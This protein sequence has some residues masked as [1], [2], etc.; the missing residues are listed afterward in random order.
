M[1]TQIQKTALLSKEKA[2]AERKWFVVDLEGKTLGRAATKIAH[3][4]RGKH[5]PSYT[6]HVDCGDFVVAINASK[7]KLTG[8]KL[9]D[10]FYYEYS[11][12]PGGLKSRSAKMLIQSDP[13]KIISLAVW[14]MLP[15]GPLGRRIHKKLK[16][17]PTHAH[18]HNAQRP[19]PLDV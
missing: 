7:V 5:K 15:K 2:Q 11:G 4:L 9:T 1:A 16:I 12:Y 14:G 3:V 10:K 17:F 8:K 6:P 19:E 18:E 13:G